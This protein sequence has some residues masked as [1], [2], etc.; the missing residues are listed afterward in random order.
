MLLVFPS[1]ISSD[2]NHLLARSGKD[3]T[4]SVRGPLVIMPV[5]DGERPLAQLG[6]NDKL[7]IVA[8]GSDD[9]VAGHSPEELVQLLESLGLAP[10]LPLRQIH[11]IVD[12]T[13]ATY[14]DRLARALAAKQ[15]RV[16]EI[17][18]PRGAVKWD[19]AGKVQ[20]LVEGAWKPSSKELNTY[21]GPDVQEKHRR[22]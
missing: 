11:L 15:F 1:G 6:E 13:G 2:V 12:H 18:A 9:D 3:G 16:R 19:E 7:H 10:E 4:P 17:K 21:A 20:V 22:S 8:S 14:A 5:A